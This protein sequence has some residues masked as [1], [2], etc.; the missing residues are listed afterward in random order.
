MVRRGV[1][2]VSADLVPVCVRPWPRGLGQIA[3]HGDRAPR[4]TPGDH[5]ELHRGQVLGL[6][7]D[8]VPVRAGPTAR[9]ERGLVQEGQIVGAPGGGAD[10]RATAPEK[11]LPLARG[12]Q[13]GG[14]PLQLLAGREQV[15]HQGGGG[16]RGPQSVHESAELLGGREL[17]LE[18]GLVGTEPTGRAECGPCLADQARPQG[19]PARL[20]GGR[21]SDD[22]GHEV[23]DPFP[24]QGRP[25][26]AH[27]QA[28]VFLQGPAPAFEGTTKKLAHSGVSLD[29]TNRHRLLGPHLCLG[30]DV[31]DGRLDNGL[32]SE[33]GQ[34][35]RDV[36]QEGAAGSEHQDA[37]TTQSGVVVE[38]ESRP[39]QPDGGLPGPGPA[40]HGEEL[41]Q[42]GPDDL[43][44][45]GL[46]GGD[47]V[48]HL[49][50]ASP[51]ELGQ[52]GV[53]AAQPGG[54]GLVTDTAEE[55]VGHRQDGAA[56]DHD[57]AASGKPQGVLGAG[58]IEGDSHRGSPVDHHGIRARVLHVA[59][60][61]A[62]A[63]ALLFVDAPEQQGSWAVR[64]E[65]DPP[66]ECG[67]VVQVRVPCCDQVLQQLLGAL[68]HGPQRS[69]RVVEGGLL[70]GHFGI[71]RGSGHAHRSR[72]SAKTRAKAPAQKSPDIPGTVLH[73]DL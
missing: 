4:C 28:D 39:M 26:E 45:F 61:D 38:E 73:L 59:T 8:D 56:I 41:V 22:G 3:E 29:L 32:F 10:G 27:T 57:L 67:H 6:V 49:A 44:L 16:D 20:V 21:S 11:E 14:V 1:G 17:A 69:E 42:G 12:E 25:G 31:A 48:E 58:S 50:R 62:P 24:I 23:V 7:H 43:V 18:P 9:E 52:Q 5:A 64:Q 13:T 19:Q 30:G 66:R 15:A 34:H 37:V 36:A 33:R 35:L 63:R 47:D 51:L 46:N 54:G 40:L 68:P 65:R 55:V 2:Q 53:A 71:G 60:A 70:G 72:I